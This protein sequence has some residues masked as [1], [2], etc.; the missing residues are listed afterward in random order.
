VTARR[1]GR[2][3]RLDGRLREGRSFD[4]S[5]YQA[6]HGRSLLGER[7]VARFTGRRNAVTWR[8][9]GARDG[10][11]LARFSTTAGGRS[12]VRTITLQR[13]NG[14]F[15]VARPFEQPTPCGAFSSFSLSSPVF[16]GTSGRSLRISYRLPR[17][18]ER[19]T[20]E[21]LV[22]SRVVKRF[23]G[24][25][26]RGRTYRFTLPAGAVARGSLVRI[27]ATILESRPVAAGSL[28]ARRL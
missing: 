10:Y 14:R 7:R 2:G 18:A 9:A 17:R 12:D 28:F 23:A 3:V 19:V 16:G 15:V 25:A 26:E 5:V 4:V 6:S 13:R 8:A 20:V 24:G 22:G 11:Y 27:R 21:A 1:S